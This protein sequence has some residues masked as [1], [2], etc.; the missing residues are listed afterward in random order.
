MVHA[1]ISDMSSNF[2]QLS[3]MLNISVDNSSFIID[4]KRLVYIFDISHLLKATRN[5]LLKYF[6]VDNK[7]TSWN[8]HIVEF[9][10]RDSK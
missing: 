9:Y 4:E 10:K 1:F 6:Q 2:I 5:N 7:I 8:F 3:H